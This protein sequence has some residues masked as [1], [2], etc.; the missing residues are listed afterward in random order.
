MSLPHYALR[1]TLFGQMEEQRYSDL[2]QARAERAQDARF[3][4]RSW[5][6]ATGKKFKTMSA[7]F[8]VLVESI[9]PRFSEI[10][11]EAD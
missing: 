6:Q 4:D 1:G 5:E 7:W 11:E 3:N 2:S 10:K 8:A 9:K